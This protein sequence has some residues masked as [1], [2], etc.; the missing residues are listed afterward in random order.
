MSK[1]NNFFLQKMGVDSSENP[2]PVKESVAAW[3]IFC[4]DIPFKLMEKV[5]EPAGRNWHDEHGCDEFIPS[6]GLYVDAY[7]MTVELACKKLS[8][9]EATTYGVSV[10]D[11]RTKVNTFL[12][13]LRQSG[14]MKMYSTHTGIG[15]Q[16]VRFVSVDNNAKWEKQDGV[17]FLVFSVTFKV[18]DPI[19]DIILT[20][21]NNVNTTTS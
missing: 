5:K 7:E 2:Y 21:T 12:T 18:N 1:W 4:K 13:Y 17:E 3:G 16:D 9:K 19:T 8:S 20:P 15:R 10:S 6:T 14:M 11:V